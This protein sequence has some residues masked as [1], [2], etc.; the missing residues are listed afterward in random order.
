MPTPFSQLSCTRP[1]VA[2][3]D[4]AHQRRLLAWKTATT[5]TDQIA[6][7]DA[8]DKDQIAFNSNA[9]LAMIHYSQ[10]TGDEARLQTKEFFDDLEPTVLSHNLS[11]LQ[12]S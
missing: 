12:C 4:Q 7:V 2:V 10:D 6:L 5:A 8:W 3:L 9:Y 11:F 1:D